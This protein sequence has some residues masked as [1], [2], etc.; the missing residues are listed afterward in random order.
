M[1][2]NNDTFNTYDEKLYE[3]INGNKIIM[4]SIDDCY[5]AYNNVLEET[6]SVF[7]EDGEFTVL[8]NIDN[9]RC[10]TILNY[11]HYAEHRDKLIC[12]VM[13]NMMKRIFILIRN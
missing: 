3:L 6:Y 11:Y 10:A 2:T 9:N 1:V 4:I 8:F 13:T 5:T 12:N 7:L